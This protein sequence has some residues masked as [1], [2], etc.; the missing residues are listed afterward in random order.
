MTRRTQQDLGQYMQEF[1]DVVLTNPERAQEILDNMKR[2]NNG[3]LPTYSTEQNRTFRTT[4]L[5]E[6]I[7]LSA[8]DMPRE[9]TIAA[10]NMLIRN[11]ADIN[12][13]DISGYTPLM[14]ASALSSILVI[15]T[16]IENGAR[17]EMSN[18]EG[19]TAVEIAIEAERGY[20]VIDYLDQI[21]TERALQN[22]TSRTERQI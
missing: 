22:F 1:C 5:H 12:A 14:D 4:L 21:R 16:L 15:R 2:E 6:V 17:I 18:D 9:A 11:G 7:E 13:Q 20:D 3:V 8:I 10:V 19:N